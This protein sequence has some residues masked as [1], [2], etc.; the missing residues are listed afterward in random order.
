MAPAGTVTEPG[1]D[2]VAPVAAYPRAIA[3]P[4]AGA[5][6]ARLTVQLDE[7]G[8]VMLAGEQE[9][10]ESVIPGCAT[11]TVTPAAVVA[12]AAPFG[13]LVDGLVTVTVEEVLRVVLES[14]KTRFAMTPSLITF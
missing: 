7:L 8:T 3:V 6:P 2:I 1:T 4:V 14:V 11:V 10:P 12:T 13:S 5:V 9:R